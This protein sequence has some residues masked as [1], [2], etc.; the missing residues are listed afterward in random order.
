MGFDAFIFARIDYQ[1]KQKRVNES[2][3]EFIWRPSPSL[4]QEIFTIV[5]YNHYEPPPGF[6]FDILCHDDPIQQDKN[7]FDYDLDQLAQQFA[8]YVREQASHTVGNDIMLTM[9]SDFHYENANENFKNIEILMK[10]IAE[11]Y[12]EFKL[13]LMYSTPSMYVDAQHAYN[14]QWSVNTDD[15]FPY[16]DHPHAYWTGYFT[17]RPAYKALLRQSNAYLQVCRHLESFQQTTASSLLLTT[18]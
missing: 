16:A 9:G 15:F 11:N 10:Y 13:N 3:L 17:S 14:H 6:C 2:K 7:L 18:R 8:D 5:T 4:D 1:D 12:K